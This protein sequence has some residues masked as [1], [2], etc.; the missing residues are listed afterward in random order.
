V[1]ILKDLRADDFGQYRAKRG[2]CPQV[3]ILKELRVGSRQ[4][5]VDRNG[6]SALGA[7][8]GKHTK[9]AE[10]IE[11]KQDASRS[12]AEERTLRGSGQARA[13]GEGVAR[14]QEGEAGAHA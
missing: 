3:L 5:A 11:K 6:K 12:G 10:G 14:R 7:I 4:L 1:R 2:E 9:S 13:R 8:P